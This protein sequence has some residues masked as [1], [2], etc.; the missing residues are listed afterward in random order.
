MYLGGVLVGG[1]EVHAASRYLPSIYER[2]GAE[3]ELQGG[4]VAGCLITCS[5]APPEKE[6]KQEPEGEADSGPCA[7]TT[8]P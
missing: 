2:L 7:H 4:P 6:K 8:S 5:D 3:S 1:D